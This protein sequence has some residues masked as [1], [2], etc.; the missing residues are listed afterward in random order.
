[1]REIKDPVNT[2][3]RGYGMRLQYKCNKYILA[4]VCTGYN[5]LLCIRLHNPYLSIVMWSKSN[6]FSGFEVH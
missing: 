3:K 4:V 5:V 2:F 6:M 1:M